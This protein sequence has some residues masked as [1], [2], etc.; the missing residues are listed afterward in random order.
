M[1]EG[2]ENSRVL[3][4]YQP[5]KNFWEVNSVEFRIPTEF[6][7]IH[8]LDKG[9]PE[10]SKIMWS[11]ALIADY[12]SKYFHMT[13]LARVELVFKDFA[14]NPKLYENHTDFIDTA[15]E[16]Y[17]DMQRDCIERELAEFAY[18]LEVRKKGI[19]RIEKI[20]ECGEMMEINKEGAL[21]TIIVDPG[22]ILDLI[23]KVD[24]LRSNT[25]KLY[26][27]YKRIQEEL[28]RKSVGLMAKGNRNQSFLENRA[29]DNGK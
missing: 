24:K 20:I 3:T 29:D 5:R 22:V 18:G 26:D 2:I 16:F 11:I 6:K 14:K 21:V 8:K 1:A 19:N 12:Q 25:A 28:S 4:I 23:F 15:I 9:G 10:S 13:R 27:D 7:L 17:N